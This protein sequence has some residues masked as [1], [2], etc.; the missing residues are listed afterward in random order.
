MHFTVITLFPEFFDSPL[1]TALMGKAR[2]QGIVSFSLVNPRDFA[3]DRH[4][5]VD[6]RPYGGGPG[7]VMMLAPLER[8]MES[9]QSSGGTGRVLMLSPRGRPLN[10]AL[11]RELA[12]EERLTLLCG[13]YEGIDARLAELHPIE[14]VSVGDYVLSGGEAGAVCLLEAVARLLPG[15]MGHEGSGEEESFSAGLLEYPHYTRPEEYKGLRVPEILLS[16]DHARIAAW[17]RQQS[18]ETT[19]AVRPE[20]LAE[21]P[22]DGEDVAYLRGKPRQRLG[23]GLFV[24]LVH[25]PVL[26]KSGRITAVSLTNLD[27][28]DISRV[29]RTYGAAGLYLVTPLRDQ[30]EMAESVLGHWVGGPGGRSNPDRQ[31][32]LRLACVRESLEAS[33]ADIEIRTGRKPRVVATSAALPRKGKGRQKLARVQQLAADDVRRWLAEGPVLLIFGTSHGL[34]PQVLSEA[35]GMLRPIR[36]LDEY[37]H[38]PVRSAVAICLDRLLADYW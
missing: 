2:E 24:A 4:R 34:A 5:T 1:T 20:L 14:E 19:L 21:T 15:F 29:S 22:L 26:D 3:T 25:Y 31:E 32:A 8:A 37:N 7:M 30:Q 9:V 36:C 13:R 10:Q 18:L 17:R 35:D 33:V 28:H 27:V 16:G 12:G 23:R 38:L 11:A 6:D